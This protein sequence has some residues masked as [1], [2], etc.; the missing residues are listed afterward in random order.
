M[1][2]SSTST[3]DFD[4]EQYDRQALRSCILFNGMPNATPKVGVQMD[5]KVL[6]ALYASAEPV[7]YKPGENIVFQ[8]QN[9]D[10][11]GVIVY[12]YVTVAQEGRM[13]V[14][15]RSAWMQLYNIGPHGAFGIAKLADRQG[16]YADVVAV[17]PTRIL[18][19]ESK[20]IFQAIGATAEAR[21]GFYNNLA[22]YLARKFKQRG[23]RLAS[24]YRMTPETRLL[25]ALMEIADN[26]AVH[27]K[28]VA[29]G[30]P[31]VTLPDKPSFELEFLA[32]WLGMTQR[33]LSSLL[34]KTQNATPELFTYT[35][36][37]R[38][39]TFQILRRP[40]LPPEP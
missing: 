24:L 22:V 30:L 9:E 31:G 29:K 2:P 19:L 23:A 8:D 37:D 28:M 27:Q 35:T 40:K 21:L 11:V 7:T 15:T 39:L 25:Q 34:K 10:V 17:M 6:D 36:T 3:A 14:T 26:H 16:H 18:T 32:S 13:E 12:G 5:Q 4:Y 1:P 33:N 38:R 20:N